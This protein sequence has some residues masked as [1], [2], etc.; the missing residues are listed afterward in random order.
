MDSHDKQVIQ[1][2]SRM[3]PG[4]KHLAICLCGGG[5]TGAAYEVGALAALEQEVPGFSANQFG[6]YI[7][8]S[9]GA[10]IATALACGVPVQRLLHAATTGDRFFAP[11]R[12]DIYRVDVRETA[13]KVGRVAS[14]LF[15]LLRAVSRNPRETLA[16]SA[17][18]DFASALP[19]GLFSLQHYIDWIDRWLQQ[20]GLPRYFDGVGPRLLITAN[21]LDTGHRE[22]FG[23]GWRVN[24]RIAE[25]IGASSAVPLFFAPVRIG[26]HDYC[27]GGTG[28]V[29]HVDLAAGASHVLIINP[30][31][32]WN[33]ERRKRDLQADDADI[34]ADSLTRIR[35]RGMIG[36][37]NQ[38][39]R[40]SNNVKLHMSLRRFRADRPEVAMALLEPDERDETLFV[41]NP[42]NT[43]ARARIAQHAFATT[44][45]R[46]RQGDP[47]LVAVCQGLSDA[48][49]LDGLKRPSGHLGG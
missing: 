35:A 27:D 40:M 38:S 28:R 31:V 48:H 19:D 22:V 46:I 47:A 33:L 41:T 15:R 43:Q 36:I 6:T 29:A 49:R 10:L 30:V 16:Q 45:A 20:N 34:L 7:G 18:V 42:M 1:L 4:A 5:A 39:F 17:L 13:W 21:D 24:A 14:G 3:V 25:A 9:A 11:S 32:P 44:V 37:W 26:Q 12:S 2:Q 23:R 8:T